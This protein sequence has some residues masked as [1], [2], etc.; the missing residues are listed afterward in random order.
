LHFFS[1]YFDWEHNKSYFIDKRVIRALKQAIKHRKPSKI[2]ENTSIH[3]YSTNS[4]GVLQGVDNT[5][6]I[7]SLKVKNH[8]TTA[9]IPREFFGLFPYFFLLI[10]QSLENQTNIIIS[11]LFWKPIA[12]SEVHCV[13]YRSFGW[14]SK[15]EGNLQLLRPLVLNSPLGVWVSESVIQLGL[16]VVS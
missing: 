16:Q 11:Y 4:L 13:I 5:H 12:I 1:A 8:Y 7:L 15:I 9:L 3:K 14:S 10:H 2:G 6:R